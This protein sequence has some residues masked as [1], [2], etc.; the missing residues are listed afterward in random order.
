MPLVAN[1]N[2]WSGEML[3]FVREIPCYTPLKTISLLPG[4]DEE[5]ASEL[6]V[7]SACTQNLNAY[8]R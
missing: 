2:Q 5:T 1:Y 3:L 6:N 8:L 7:N 4:S